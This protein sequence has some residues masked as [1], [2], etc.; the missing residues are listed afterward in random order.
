MRIPW[1]QVKQFV[2]R[3][4]R[5]RP[6]GD[7]YKA[8]HSHTRW[9]G[10]LQSDVSFD[11]AILKIRASQKRETALLRVFC[12]A[13][14][15]TSFVFH[16]FGLHVKEDQVLGVAERKRLSIRRRLTEAGPAY[17][18]REDSRN[19]AS[20]LCNSRHILLPPSLNAG[21]SAAQSASPL[22]KK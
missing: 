22:A 17:C 3:G 1:P 5:P 15:F 12:Q 16:G 6:E 19:R 11:G 2:P 20:H 9:R 10:Y 7:A 21:T 8:G 18:D 13:H 4:V 14:R